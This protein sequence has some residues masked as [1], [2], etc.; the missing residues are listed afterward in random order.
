MTV[1]LGNNRNVWRGFCNILFKTLTNM[2]ADH[3]QQSTLTSRALSRFK[4]GDANPWSSELQLLRSCD[5]QKWKQVIKSRSCCLLWWLSVNRKYLQISGEKAWR[6]MLCTCLAS[7]GKALQCNLREQ[8]RLGLLWWMDG[9]HCRW[10]GRQ[11]Y[12]GI[13]IPK[14][15]RSVEP[16]RMINFKK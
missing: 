9:K 14:W 6:C 12:M 7:S 15:I 8:S 3:V 16:R 11:L 10:G 4:T 5:F 13:I 1:W 2:K